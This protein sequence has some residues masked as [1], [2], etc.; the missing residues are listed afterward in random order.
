MMIVIV[1]ISPD[2]KISLQNLKWLS[3]LLWSIIGDNRLFIKI[4]CGNLG[5]VS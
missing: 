5:Y 4:S 2:L 3:D 1:M